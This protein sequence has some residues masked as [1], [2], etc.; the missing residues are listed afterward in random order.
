MKTLLFGVSP[1][2]DP[3]ILKRIVYERTDPKI[4][5]DF[6][7][8]NV[9]EGTGR[10]LIMQ[11][12]SGIPP[13][14]DTQGKGKIRRG[15]DC[16][17][18]TG[19][20]RGN[21]SI[22]TG[23]ADFTAETVAR[24]DPKYLSSIALEVL[25]DQARKELAPS[26]LLNLTDI[27]LLTTLGLIRRNKLTRAAILLV[28][29][30][31]AIM[32]FAPGNNWTFLQ[33]VSDTK[34]INKEDRVSALPI[35]IQRIEEL[36]VPFN[37]ITTYEEGLYHFEYRTWPETALREALMNSYSHTDLRIAGPILVKLYPDRLEISNNGGFIGGITPNNILHHQPAS[38]NPLLIE[39]LTKLRLVNRS[40]LGISRMFTSLLIEGK[41]P[42]FIED[43]GD[44][45]LVTFAK[46]TL[47]S[48]FRTFVAEEYKNN[49]NLDVD[50]LLILKYLL[51][52]PEIDPLSA[53]NLCHMSVNRIREKLLV[54]EN[55]RYIF[56]GGVGR[57]TYW[58]MNPELYARFSKNATDITHRHYDWDTAKKTVIKILSDR[59][60]YSDAGLS[61]QEIRQFIHFNRNQVY[62]LMRELV[63]ETPYLKLIGRGRY[64]RYKMLK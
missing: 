29:N 32:Q 7:V 13:Y 56:H 58:F 26:D 61:N 43:K 49:R 48:S 3:N 47:N 63:N 5:P 20:I 19:T 30:E 62:R 42:P 45:I 27:D 53:S 51:R 50:E 52:H 35:Y 14:T 64:A 2:I 40:N 59:T 39:A 46:S 38:R 4:T 25:R 34:Y 8:L 22:E 24:V 44:S 41:E 15:K 23:E 57:D 18:L 28:G 21:I 12:L 9:P 60:K 17:P 54:M 37:P 31:E 16:V 10:L 33:M 55:K 11:I 36:L 6:E 1:E